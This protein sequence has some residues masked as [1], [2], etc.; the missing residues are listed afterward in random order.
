M[1]WT[2]FIAYREPI[3]FVR[4]ADECRQLLGRL[5]DWRSV[6]PLE[7]ESSPGY[8]WAK[9]PPATL[10]PAEDCWLLGLRGIPSSIELGVI[11]SDDGTGEYWVDLGFGAPPMCY[12][13][14]IAAAAVLADLND[15]PV[16]DGA[17][18]FSDH[19]ELPAA[20][21]VEAVV[22]GGGTE[23]FPGRL[24]GAKQLAAATAAG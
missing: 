22:S 21:F 6:P 3:P 1:S 23:N 12:A 16:R 19:F 15:A 18:A 8:P 4:F 20:Q 13:L 7:P 10:G 9:E 2:L 14:F 11:R 5:L 24:T 17:K